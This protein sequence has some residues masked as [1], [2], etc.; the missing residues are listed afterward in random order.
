M[1]Y[2]GLGGIKQKD[3]V[4]ELQLQED[5]DLAPHFLDIIFFLALLDP[6]D[7]TNCPVNSAWACRQNRRL[8]ALSATMLGSYPAHSNYFDFNEYLRK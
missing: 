1:N 2:E 6:L 8:P 5:T 3:D 4:L 7:G